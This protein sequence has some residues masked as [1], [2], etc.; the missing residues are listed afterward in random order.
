MDNQNNN[1]SALCPIEEN[2]KSTPP[3]TSRSF[4]ECAQ[5]VL[6]EFNNNK[7]PMHYK[8]ITEKALSKGWLI[9]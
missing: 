5:K 1:R 9:T 6:E 3:S 2:P 7:N 8:E 4:T